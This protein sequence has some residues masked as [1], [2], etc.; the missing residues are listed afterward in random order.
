M[1]RS[2]K[3]QGLQMKVGEQC[4][5]EKQWQRFQGVGKEIFTERVE[6]CFKCQSFLQSVY[7][8]GETPARYLYLQRKFYWSTVMSTHLVCYGCFH[9]QWRIVQLQANIWRLCHMVLPKDGC[10]VLTKF[11]NIP[12]SQ[13]WKQ[14]PFI[15]VLMLLRRGLGK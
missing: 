9:R 11:E 10:L 3:Y 12:K 7:Q 6:C 4:N 5:N 14:F 8:N 1:E 15:H 13:C 2:E